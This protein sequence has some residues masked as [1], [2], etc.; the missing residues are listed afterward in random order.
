MVLPDKKVYSDKPPIAHI[1]SLASI[2]DVDKDELIEISNSI[3]VL[4]KPGKLLLK[5]NGDP[6]PTIDAKPR[7]KLL[8]EKIKN[9]LLKEAHYP[10]YLLGGI[11][12]R[13]IPRDYKRHASIHSGKCILIS[14]D[15]RDFFPNS[16]FNV[17]HDIWKYVFRCAPEVAEILAKITTLKSSLPQGWKTSSYLANLVFWDSEPE[18]V[19][20]L[21]R[22]GF[23]YSRFMDDITVSS[24]SIINNAQKKYIV[25]EIYRMLFS[26]G[27]APKRSKHT[28]T[29]RGSR[30]EVTGLTVNSKSPSL[31][32]KSNIRAAVH[33]CE[34]RAR[35]GR[36]SRSY[37][38]LWHSISGDVST[39][40]RFHPNKGKQ[41]RERLRAIKPI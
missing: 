2:L 29:S 1:E 40:T 25:G 30:M 37:N 20:R 38:K 3:D 21:E 36:Q 27:Y 24:R 33:H 6:R 19:A 15:I 12:D 16:S 7:L 35:F 14:E 39:L 8:H 41:L 17:V 34:Q 10:I 18:L 28:I 13:E 26:K 5:K 23:T 31:P 11:K 22:R 9:R 32:H 4:W